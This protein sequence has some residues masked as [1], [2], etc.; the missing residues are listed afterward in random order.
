MSSSCRWSRG[1]SPTSSSASSRTPASSTSTTT[2][3]G[4]GRRWCCGPRSCCS[5]SPPAAAADDDYG[6][7]RCRCSAVAGGAGGAH[8]SLYM[9][10]FQLKQHSTALMARST[11]Y[12]TRGARCVRVCGEDGLFLACMYAYAC[13]GDKVQVLDDMCCVVWHYV[14]CFCN[15]QLTMILAGATL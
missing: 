10:E 8:C 2:A 12:K 15:C 4:S 3:A 14:R 1:T 5:R 13:N 9:G 7:G 11:K 6:G